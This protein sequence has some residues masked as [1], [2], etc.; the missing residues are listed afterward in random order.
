MHV[1]PSALLLVPSGHV[2]F[3]HTTPET[4]TTNNLAPS[5]SA[6]ARLA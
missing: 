2:V 6:L 5:R 4:F 1:P 3:S